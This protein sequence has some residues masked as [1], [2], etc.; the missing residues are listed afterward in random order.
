MSDALPQISTSLRTSESKREK[1]LLFRSD[2]PV[3][4]SSRAFDALLL[5]DHRPRARYS[6]EGEDLMAAIWPD[7]VVRRENNL[8]QIISTHRRDPRGISWCESLYRDRFR[9]RLPLAFCRFM[10]E[11]WTLREEHTHIRIGVLPFENLGA[12]VEREYLSDGLTEETIAMIG[13]IDPN[14]FSVIGRTSVMS[15]KKTTKTLTDIGRELDASYLI[16]GS[17][18]AEGERLRITCKL[19]RVRDQLQIWSA[20]YDREPGSLLAFQ[21]ELALAIAEQVRLQLSPGRL[22]A[23]ANRQT[24]NPDAYDLYLRGRY[25]FNQFAPLA[26]RRSID[27]FTQAAASGPR[28]MRWP[29]PA[30]PRTLSH[31]A[32]FRE[33]TAPLALL[34]RAREAAEN[35]LRS[36]PHLA[37]GTNILRLLPFVAGLGLGGCREGFS[38]RPL[39]QTQTMHSLLACSGYCCRI[40]VATR[41]QLPRSDARELDPL[42]AMNR[43]LILTNRFCRARHRGRN[44][45][46]ARSSHH[47]SRVFGSGHF[48]LAQAFIE[49]AGLRPRSISDLSPRQAG[50]A[51]ETARPSRCAASTCWSRTP[52]SAGDA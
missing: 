29:G 13:Q 20:S 39:S 14:H 34:S 26:T 43:A 6:R 37:E 48:Q 31:P 21:R 4:I 9:Q 10:R 32:R 49:V 28:I 45:I 33:T 25:Y 18:R 47:R 30:L 40:F 46:C 35:A 24:H 52:D 12:G 50:S 17:L 8:N 36:D 51:G 15:Y 27:Y 1:R 7:T 5:P 3:P 42:N 38:R 44:S 2:N 22:K 41:R 11:R 16:E 23:L 19:I